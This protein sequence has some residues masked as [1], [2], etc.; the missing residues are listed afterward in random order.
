MP[1]TLYVRDFAADNLTDSQIIAA[2][3]TARPAGE[4]VTIILDGRDFHIDEAILLDDFTTFIIDGCA[5]KQ[6]DEVFD[7]V[8]RGANVIINPEN[9]FGAPLEVRP[10]R[11]I[12]IVGQNGARIIGCDINRKGYHPPLGQTLDMTGD[13]WGW[14]VVQIC[15]SRCDGFD[16][17]G[18][19]LLQSRGWSLSFDGCANG[20]VHDITIE[21]NV[22]NGDGV[23]FRAGC[24]DCR[25][26]NIRGYTSD[27]SI[28]CTALYEAGRTYPFKNYLYPHEPYLAT[29]GQIAPHELD[30]YNIDIS[31]VYTGGEHH[32]V[33]CLAANGLQVHHITIRNV[34][35]A[36]R[37]KRFSCVKLYTGYGSGYQTGDLHHITIEGITSRIAKYAVECNATVE[38]VRLSAI[39]Q[40]TPD[41]ELFSL[42]DPQGIVIV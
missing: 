31:G 17:S 13:F 38:A 18:L 28:A 8:F 40:L 4:A 36:E 34:E 7:N 20:Y 21:S 16:V 42:A 5:I 39:R 33:I 26:E 6:N 30:I 9:P 1:H 2:C 14:R 29:L 10:A 35:E 23:D 41:G 22:K 15:L 3:L 32:G 11:D 37:G 24:H 19:S 12:R 27:D 25:A